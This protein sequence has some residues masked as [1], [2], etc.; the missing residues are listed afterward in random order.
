[1]KK[2]AVTS[3][4]L[5]LIGI[6]SFLS[7]KKEETMSV[8]S[9]GTVTTVANST[10]MVG[11]ACW[12]YD[13]CNVS[14]NKMKGV[15]GSCTVELIFGAS[16]I[17]SNYALTGGVPAGGQVQMKIT[18][19]PSQPPGIWYSKEGTLSVT[20]NA[21]G[22]VASFTNINCNQYSTS[23]PTVIASGSVVCY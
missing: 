5:L 19:P 7:C 13:S 16:P 10:L 11:G 18:N 21:S 12:V 1:M 15:C 6:F 17:S 14:P 20:Y 9:C 4:F 22:K 3:V 23:N 2:I 8:R